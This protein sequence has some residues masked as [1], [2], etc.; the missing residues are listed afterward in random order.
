MY[1]LVILFL[2]FLYYHHASAQSNY[3]P[4]YIIKSEGETVRGFIDFQEWRINPKKI[5]FKTNESEKSTVMTAETMKGFGID[6]KESYVLRAV[7]VNIAP[8]KLTALTTSREPIFEKKTVFL[9]VL[10]DGKANLY[11]LYDAVGKEHYFIE[12]NDLP[13]EE[14]IYTE[15]FKMVKGKRIAAPFDQ[16]KGQLNKTLS[17]CDKLFPL[18]KDAEYKRIDLMSIFETYNTCDSASDPTSIKRE[19]VK[20]QVESGVLV[21]LGANTLNFTGTITYDLGDMDFGISPAYSFGGYL[22]LQGERSR[23]RYALRNEL[24]YNSIGGSVHHENIQSEDVYTISDIK[25]NLGYLQLNTL[26]RYTIPTE[27]IRP[28]INVG[29]GMGVVITKVNEIDRE[30]KFYAL[31]TNETNKALNEIKRQDFSA[32][33]GLGIATARL[34]SELRFEFG[35][36]IVPY[37][38]S[39]GDTKTLMIVVSYKLG[40]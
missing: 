1:K 29:A 38:F 5:R 28:Y 35:K 21:G 27:K 22:N 36:K 23:G 4:G 37:I 40:K 17:N 34:S 6:N 24:I 8:I 11:F 2:T 12:K 32:V 18:L 33:A 25:L 31:P 20:F 14:L 19:K 26:F 13:A 3:L 9:R 15:Y 30:R 7:D 16:Y 10:V 39:K